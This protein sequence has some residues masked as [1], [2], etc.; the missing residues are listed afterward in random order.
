MRS[1]ARFLVVVLLASPAVMRAE[2]WEHTYPVGGTPEILVDTNDGDVEVAVGSSDQVVAR[3]I[4][5]G[6]KIND[7]L[8]IQANGTQSR[9]ELRLHRE[10]RNCFGFC[11]Q[12]I[13]VELRVPRESNLDIHSGDGNVR[14]ESVRGNHRIESNDGDLRLHEL[15]GS[16]HANTHDGTIRVSG[17]FA[18]LELHT[19]DGD[20]NAEVS[21]ALSPKTGW[22]LRSGDGTVRLRL[23]GDFRADLD[24][25]TGDGEIRVAFPMEGSGQKSEHAMRGKINGGGIPLELQT[26]DGDIHVE[27]M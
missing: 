3:V 14:V 13:R 2:E 1:F 4:S 18:L 24:A 21:G 11:F 10:S 19:G 16:L 5:H 23:P 17:H 20:I 26:G 7:D 6:L 25:R 15:E 8:R 12:S 22:S 9:I 27:S